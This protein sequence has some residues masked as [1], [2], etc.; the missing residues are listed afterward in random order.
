MISVAYGITYIFQTGTVV[1]PIAPYYFLFIF[2][3]GF[4]IFTVYLKR[5]IKAVYPREI[6]GGAMAS[7]C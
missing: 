1:F 5:E 2:S 7:A 6:I 4:V 3:I